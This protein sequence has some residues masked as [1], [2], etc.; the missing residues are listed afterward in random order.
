MHTIVKSSIL[1]ALFL[2]AA[3]GS[4]AAAPQILG[5]VASAEPTPLYCQGGTCSADLTAF[6]LQKSRPV[7]MS[8]TLYSIVGRDRVAL[9]A[10]TA[11]GARVPLPLDKADVHVPRGLSALRVSVSEAQLSAVGGVGAEILVGENVAAVP[12]PVS[13]DPEPLTIEEIAY[14]TGP[15]RAA[16]AGLFDTD[17]EAA[18]AVRIT[19]KLIN[20]N[21][22]F[23][24]MPQAW[25][26][27]LWAKTLGDVPTD[28]PA[29][30]RA[31]EAYDRCLGRDS[32][33]YFSLRRCLE[34]RHD[35]MQMEL[36]HTYWNSI[37]AGY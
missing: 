5:V 2:A 22:L 7:P 18:R 3:A 29:T 20:A 9:V 25:N 24:R 6:C 30:A 12:L 26:R 10:V 14:V 16:A 23:G 15:L 36:N 21:P 17:D 1:A 11:D 28:D 33:F 27:E 37:G 4:A 31:A 35:R 34:A 13:G 8:G 32:K 19:G